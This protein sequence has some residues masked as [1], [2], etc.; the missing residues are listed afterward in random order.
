MLAT[1]ASHLGVWEYDLEANHLRCD[2]RWYEIFGIESRSSVNS[3][4]AFN[5]CVH[6]EDI[7]RVTRERLEAL[8]ARKKIH[9]D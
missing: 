7:A 2:E 5:E 8:A 9:R 6:P 3:I 1:E 4:E